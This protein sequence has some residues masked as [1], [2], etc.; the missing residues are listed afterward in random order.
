MKNEIKKDHLLTSL[1]FSAE[2]VKYQVKLRG[3][4]W[5]DSLARLGDPEYK[6]LANR[7]TKAVNILLFIISFRHFLIFQIA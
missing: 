5:K 3:E 1:L 4:T 6:E 7:I 2:N